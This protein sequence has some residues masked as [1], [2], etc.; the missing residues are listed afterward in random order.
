MV[1][2]HPLFGRPLVALDRPPR[3]RADQRTGRSWPRTRQ[4]HTDMPTDILTECLALVAEGIGRARSAPRF[5]LAQPLPLPGARS[6]SG[7][8]VA[9]RTALRRRG[10]GG[11]P[12]RAGT[13]RI[14]AKS[15]ALVAVCRMTQGDWSG[16][17]DSMLAALGNLRDTGDLAGAVDA[18]TAMGVILVELGDMVQ[19]AGF[20][21]DAITEA[22]ANRLR[23]R[24]DL[25]R[26]DRCLPG[27][28]AAGCTA[29][30]ATMDDALAE[31]IG[32]VERGLPRGIFLD[33]VK[34]IDRARVGG[35][36]A[37]HS[38]ARTAA[39][40]AGCERAPL[41]ISTTLAAGARRP[42][43]TAAPRF[44]ASPVDC[45]D[46]TGRPIS[47]GRSRSRSRAMPPRIAS[48]RSD[49]ARTADPG[50]DRQRPD[51]C[52]NCRRRCSCRAKTVMHHSTSIYRKLEVGG[53]AEAVA[54]AYRTG[55]LHAPATQVT[56]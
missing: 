10:G 30:A 22:R 20:L 29:D 49:G 54:L 37:Q 27:V 53:R 34:S 15:Q 23:P 33:Y 25:R 39:A 18:M 8:P 7:C 3:L 56:T 32:V 6:W 2:A 11:R 31:H 50:R 46:T 42:S 43:A 14:A 52:A 19:A 16:A 26:L 47:R 45:I 41:E 17:R 40:G 4:R 48:A 36:A 28:P 21:R 55:L 5:L 51:Q 24:R 44:D 12:G 38:A 35:R 13:G 1:V 9:G